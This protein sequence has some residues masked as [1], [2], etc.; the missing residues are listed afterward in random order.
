MVLA[1]RN[2]RSAQGPTQPGSDPYILCSAE[3][4]PLNLTEAIRHHWSIGNNLHWVL[5]VVLREDDSR[6]REHQA[7]QN[8]ALLQ[9]IALNLLAQDPA[10]ISTKA[11]RKRP[12]GSTTPRQLHALAQWADHPL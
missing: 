6:I 2:I 8:W 7:V 11:K 9:K 10:K 12:P 4:E 5:D 1:V 3:A